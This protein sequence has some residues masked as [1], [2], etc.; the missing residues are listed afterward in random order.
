[1]SPRRRTVRELR[2]RFRVQDSID[3]GYRTLREYRAFWGMYTGLFE[4]YVYRESGAR[5]LRN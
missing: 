2:K 5:E 1:M 4:K 3:L